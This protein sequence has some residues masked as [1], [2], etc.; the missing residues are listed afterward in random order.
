MP[1]R[2]S[3]TEG[4]IGFAL[5]LARKGQCEQAQKV[6]QNLTGRSLGPSDLRLV[7]Q[8][9]TRCNALDRAELC[10]LEIE[11]RAAMEPGDFYMLGSLQMRLSKFEAA[12]CCSQRE[13][14][15]SSKTGPTYFTN[16]AAIKLAE[17]ELQQGRPKRARDALADV[18]DQVGDYVD[19]VG[20]R[21]KATILRDAVRYETGN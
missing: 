14:E 18:A 19:G 17:L 9:N 16:S 10:W 7:A 3:S 5:R 20:F 11:R 21:T 4:W 6:L 13:L 2:F 1:K 12:I 8:V 15:I